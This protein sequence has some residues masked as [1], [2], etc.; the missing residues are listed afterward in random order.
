[1]MDIADAT[2]VAG[3]LD[4]L[5]DAGWVL[6]ATC[7]RT[8]KE[9]AQ[10]TMHKEHPQA[11]FAQRIAEQCD[12]VH[13]RTPGTDS[14]SP[15]D[16]RRTLT[17]AKDP[18]FLSP[19]DSSTAAALEGRFESAL[20]G[21]E[22]RTTVAHTG[23]NRSLNLIGSKERG[24]ARTS[25]AALC[26]TPL[27]AIDYISLAQQFYTIFV[28]DVPQLSLR[29][30]DQARR[31]ITLVDQLYNHRT[32]LVASAAVPLTN[33]FEGAAG[34]EVLAELEAQR[35]EGLEFEGEAGKAEELNPIGVTANSLADE[36]ADV[37]SLTGRVGADSRK[38]LAQD[39][40]FT[41]EDETFA[42]RRAISRLTEMQSEEYLGRSGA[43]RMDMGM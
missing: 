4:R 33:L 18:A 17:A 11:R 14:E 15:R 31:F 19:L 36:A 6:V 37:L 16:Y 28:T 12:A 26:D 38:R 32:Q 43:K 42:F 10:S 7:N 35:L 20:A 3:V 1:M 34:G 30:R 39:S 2:I 25:F 40:L 23:P 21:A 24:V 13:L 27:G 8:P 29:S 5:F 9:F 22:A 41:G